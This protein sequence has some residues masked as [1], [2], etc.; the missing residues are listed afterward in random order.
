M[1]LRSKIAL[2]YIGLAVA[3]IA[4]AS[5]I[6]SW[7]IKN[8]LDQRK[9]VPFT[10]A[11][12]LGSQEDVYGDRERLK[13]VMINLIENAL[14]YTDRGGSVEVAVAE[15]GSRCIVWVKD[16]GSGIGSEHVEHIFGRFY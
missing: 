6:S 4:L 12:A 15:E 3:G 13:Q 8:D 11:S 16:T 14:K 10:F 1:K 5:S 2:T 9:H 7:Q